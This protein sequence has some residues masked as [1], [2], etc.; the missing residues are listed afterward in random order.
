[1]IKNKLPALFTTL[2]LVIAGCSSAPTVQSYYI[3]ESST[4][5]ANTITSGA[6]Y[7]SIRKVRLP[8]YASKQG[9]VTQT[10]DDSVYLSV[11]DLW[12]DPL[13]NTV[14]KV[15][16][17]ELSYQVGKPVMVNPIPPGHEV[18]IM[19]EVDANRLIADEKS[20]H[21]NADYRL[22]T[23]N[24]IIASSYVGEVNLADSS[25]KSLVSAHQQV[26]QDFA[27]AIATTLRQNNVK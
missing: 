27:K 5:A 14:P 20:L 1:M 25:T 8:D 7:M 23:P 11:A 4:E 26:M 10:S 16:A 18:D 22:I 13:S 9:I 12:I 21:L 2:T 3:L 17:K 15:L 19:L 24:D 6:P